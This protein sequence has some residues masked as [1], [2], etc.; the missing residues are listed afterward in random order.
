M[1]YVVVCSDGSYGYNRNQSCDGC[2]S[3]S[4]EKE[5]GVCTDTSGC[6]PG[7]QHGQP[8]CDK[9]IRLHSIKKDIHLQAAKSSTIPQIRR[10]RVAQWVR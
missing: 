4:C 7:W 3:D 9:G 6:K 10:A 1:F 5:L 8:K 2:L